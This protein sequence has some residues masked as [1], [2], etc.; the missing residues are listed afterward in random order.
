MMHVA[1]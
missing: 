1:A